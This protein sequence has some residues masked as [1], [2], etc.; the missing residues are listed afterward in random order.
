MIIYIYIYNLDLALNDQRVMI[1]HKTQQINYAH[2]H[3]YRYGH[4]QEKKRQRICDLI[5]AKTKPIFLSNGYKAKKVFL[6][7]KALLR[8]SGTGGVN[9]NEKKAFLTVWYSHIHVPAGIYIYILDTYRRNDKDRRRK[10]SLWIYISL[11][12]FVRVRKG[13]GGFTVRGSWRSNITTIFRL[14]Y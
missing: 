8:K 13:C 12:S 3:P 11:T 1:C 6:Q 7:K 2:S 9:K 5:K 10:T 4:E 14:P